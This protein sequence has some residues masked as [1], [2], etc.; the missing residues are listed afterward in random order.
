MKQVGRNM[1]VIE[2]QNVKY[3]YKTKYQSVEALRG[4][5][6][7]FETGK[8]YTIMGSS[9]CGKTTLLSLMAGLDVP[10][11]GD[12]LFEGVSTADMNLENTVAS[13]WR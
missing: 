1:N 9:G 6:Y 4:I 11:E 5:S 10:T 8:V 2:L 7:S 3:V 13:A 12:V